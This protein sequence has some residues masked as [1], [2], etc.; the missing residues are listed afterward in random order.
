M[1]ILQKKNAYVIMPVGK[2]M[3]CVH[4]NAAKT[5][6]FAPLGFFVRLCRVDETPG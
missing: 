6:E 2:M 4:S 3:K 5:P 1:R